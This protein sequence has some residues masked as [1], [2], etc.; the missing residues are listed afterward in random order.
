MDW[1]KGYSA[2]YYAARVDPVTWRDVER[3]EITGGSIKRGVDALREM[4]RASD[5]GRTVD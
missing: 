5:R 2:S 4:C 3:F 1:S